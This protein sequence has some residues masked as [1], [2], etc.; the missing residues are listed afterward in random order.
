MNNIS[1]VEV[2]EHLDKEVL[3]AI[4]VFLKSVESI[5]QPTDFLPLSNEDSFFDEVRE[6]REKANG[7]SYDLLAV[8]I[9]DTLTEE[10]LPTYE[11]WLSLIKPVTEDS[12]GGWHQWV[13]A[14]TSEENRH[15]DILNKYLYLS[16]RVNMRE[17]EIST[18]YLLADGFDIGTAKDPY[19]TF[20]YTSFQELA[21]N[22]SHRRV[23]QIAKAEGDDLL[24][25]ICGNVASDEMRHA[26]AYKSF[27]SKILQLDPNEM[28]IAFED[29]MRRKIVMPAHLLRE[30][31]MP[32]GSAFTH[33]SDAAQ[34]IGVYTTSDYINIL[35]SLIEEWKI[36]S[37]RNLNEQGERA[38]DYVLM[39]PDRL[40]KIAQRIKAQPATYKFSWIHQ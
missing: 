40:T 33:F 1:K 27:V 28:M 38:R 30:S 19:R 6:L 25:R 14:W 12:D 34:R 31:G 39:L 7:L 3:N 37:L 21:T 4:P 17:M 18:Q 15:G 29:M 36:D 16:G 32:K 8:L 35:L 13:R 26:G 9:G 20:I 2:M 11:T 24:A 23:A 22:L 5:W 10:A